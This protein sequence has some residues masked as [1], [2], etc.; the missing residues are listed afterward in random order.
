MRATGCIQ[1][2]FAFAIRTNFGGGS[3]RCFRLF[4]QRHQLVEPAQEQED[5][6]CH[7]DKVDDRGQKRA[8]F[9]LYTAD[10]PNPCGKI[11]LCNQTEQ[12]GNDVTDQRTD[13]GLKR[14]ADDNANGKVNHI[15]PQSKFFEFGKKFFHRKS[16]LTFIF[17]AQ[18][19][20]DINFI[21][22]H[23]NGNF[24]NNFLRPPG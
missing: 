6:E 7:Q 10:V 12:R 5:D 2:D 21:V 9:N 13:D 22:A 18:K 17:A 23:R 4:A 3:L 24:Q 20:T 1:G 16:L 19:T 11:F 15:A 14:A 8:V